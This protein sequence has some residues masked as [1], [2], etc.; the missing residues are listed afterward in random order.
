MTDEYEYGHCMNCLTQ[1]CGID[2][3]PNGDHNTTCAKCKAEEHHD[4]DAFPDVTFD[5]AGRY[6]EAVND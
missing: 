3:D 6:V 5:R 4:F 1:M 2:D